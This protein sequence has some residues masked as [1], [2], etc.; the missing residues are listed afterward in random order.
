MNSDPRI[1]SVQNGKCIGPSPLSNDTRSRDENRGLTSSRG[2]FLA[3]LGERMKKEVLAELPPYPLPV[4]RFHRNWRT[5]LGLAPAE[6]GPIALVMDWEHLLRDA[7]RCRGLPDSVR[8]IGEATAGRDWTGIAVISDDGGSH[9]AE[10]C[11]QLERLGLRSRLITFSPG[12]DI[13][14]TAVIRETRRLLAV[15]RD[16]PR[17]DVVRVCVAASDRA[18]TAIMDSGLIANERLSIARYD[19]RPFNKFVGSGISLVRL[20]PTHV[21]RLPRRAS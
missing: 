20:G 4:A 15:L 17:G 13:F 19:W 21:V 14:D 10:S 7:R 11:E 5:A 3:L 1:A 18:I 9:A 2:H 8:I 12:L 16:A 6:S